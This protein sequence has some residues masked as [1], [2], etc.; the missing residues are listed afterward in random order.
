MSGNNG[1][2]V[3]LNG[4]VFRALAAARSLRRQ[5]RVAE[6]EALMAAVRRMQ[7]NVKFPPSIVPRVKG[8]WLYRLWSSSGELLY[9]GIT[10]RGT[11]REREHARTKSWWPQVH[12]VTVEPVAT[13]AELRHLEA[14]AI[15]KESPLYNIQHNR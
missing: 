6:S 13:R 5:G 10:D 2:D 3:T 1:A 15:R 14:V 12:H 4:K 7:R 9:I 11:A 8:R